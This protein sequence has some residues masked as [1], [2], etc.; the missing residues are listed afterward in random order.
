MTFAASPYLAAP[1]SINRPTAVIS[2]LVQTFV[3]ALF[4]VLAQ[5]AVPAFGYTSAP[6]FALARSYPLP[7]GNLT[8]SL[9]PAASTSLMV[10]YNR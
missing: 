9:D 2:V 4:S 1:F 7:S 6:P 3:A 8:M 10:L 5:T